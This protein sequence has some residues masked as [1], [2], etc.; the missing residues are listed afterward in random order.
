MIT[1]G[2]Y[3]HH[4]PIDCYEE[5]DLTIGN[6]CSIGSGLKIYSGEH[7]CIAYPDVVSTFAF[8]EVWNE[9]YYPSKMGGKV[10]IGNDVWIATDVGI[11]EGVTIGDG[12]IIGAG[13]LVTKDVPPYA[14]VAGNPAEVKKYRFEAA[15]IYDL[16]TIRWWDWDQDQ[17]KK[18]MPYM[19]DVYKFIEKYG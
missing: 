13:S 14:F 4:T 3:T 1:Y 11:L 12:A 10:T 2:S 5:V 17:I 18:A 9:E 6:F 7:P 19:S 8:K 16:L 15:V